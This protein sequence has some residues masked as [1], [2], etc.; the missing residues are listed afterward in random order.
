MTQS[1]RQADIQVTP[2]MIEAGAAILLD[3]EDP[4][5]DF[6]WVLTAIFRAMLPLMPRRSPPL[7]DQQP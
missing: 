6:D 3:S 1:Q 2:E 7:S 4:R 5:N